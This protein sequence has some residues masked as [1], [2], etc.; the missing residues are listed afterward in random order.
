MHDHDTRM[1]TRRR[2]WLAGGTALLVTLIVIALVW[3]WNWFKG[4]VQRQVEQRSGRSFSI[5]GNLDVALGWRPRVMLEKIRLG[6]ADWAR[7]PQMFSAERVEVS[8]DLREL[9]AGRWLLPEVTLVAPRLELETAPDGRQNWQFAKSEKQDDISPISALPQIGTLRIDRGDLRYFDPKQD[10]DV[11]LAIATQGSGASGTASD[12]LIA[13]ARGRF[14]SATVAADASGAGVL[15]LSNAQTPYP[16]RASFRIGATR[17]K[18]DGTVTGLQAFGAA[19][20]NIDLRGDSLAALHPLTALALPET[21]PYHIKG[22]LIREG[23]RWTFNDFKGQVGDSDLAGDVTVTYTDGRPRM[24]AKLQS[25]QLDLDDLAGFV[26]GTPDTG[27]GETASAQQTR[28]AIKEDSKARMLPDKR[29]DLS[30]LRSMDADVHFSGLSIRNKSA[31]LDRLIVHLLLDKGQLRLDPLDFGI[32]GGAIVSRVRIDA[33]EPTLAMNAKLDFRRLDLAKLMPGNP[34][35]VAGAGLIGGRAQLSG[36]GGSTAA[37]LASLDGELGIAMRGGK[38]SNL[39]MEGVGLD[40]A[41]A[42]RLFVVGDRSIRL[43]CAVMDFAA[44]D[45]VLTARSFIVDTTDTNVHVNGSL[46]LRDETLDLKLH[47]LP[48]DWSPLS[49]RTP[50]HVRGT[51]KNPQVR[52]D[53]KLIVRGGVVAVLAALVNPLAALLPLIETGPGKNEDCD[54]LVAAVQR[55][56]VVEARP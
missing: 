12:S 46:S 47:P 13:K 32:A 1:T 42:L 23:T 28:A 14:R 3:D 51:F 19:R 18:V 39:L 29:M 55:Q 24:V 9:I 5:D 27:P 48:K 43:R 34:T 52:P 33:R 56:V 21:P 38:F 10:T 26:G 16:F 4:P 53:K 40:A 54:A 41:E 37:L 49:L 50:L 6:N 25:R 11:A 20:L 35:V 15:A 22:L 44:Q 7:T 2:R 8:V 36:N 30:L 45:G 17:G 31:P